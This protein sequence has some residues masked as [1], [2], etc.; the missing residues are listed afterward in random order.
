MGEF[1]TLSVAGYEI[2]SWKNCV[3]EE[4]A[5]LFTQDDEVEYD[6]VIEYEY[7]SLGNAK[8]LK[9]PEVVPGYRYINTAKNIIDRL[10]LIGCTLEASKERF[11]AGINE[12]LL[13]L[14]Q[15][16]EM[17]Q[18][19]HDAERAFYTAFTF[20]TWSQLMKRVVEERLEKIFTWERQDKEHPL[21][22]ENPILYRMLVSSDYHTFCFPCDYAAY[23]YRALLEVVK[24]SAYVEVDFT[25]LVGWVE[26]E[27]YSCCPPQQMLL[28][29]GSSD[30]RILQETLR[31]H[32]PHL[33]DYFSFMDFDA[34]SMPGGT[35]SLLNIVKAFIATGKGGRCIAL[36]DNDTAGH[37]ALRQLNNIKLPPYIKAMALPTLE[38]AKEYPTIGPQGVV[39]IDINGS[40]CSIELYLGRDV[41]TDKEGKLTPVH[42]GSFVQGM[43]RYQGELQ[44]KQAIQ[45]KYIRLLADMGRNPLLRQQHDWSGMVTL[46]EAIFSLC[47]C[48]G[49]LLE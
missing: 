42:W 18:D 44:N 26:E 43:R 29:E 7:D 30:K 45:E 14:E 16:N 38:L 1:A 21:K 11:Q 5:S 37:D 10:E 8:R 36:F 20:E 24:P 25:F 34:S 33:F 39:N 12:K 13:R 48:S 46:F 15:W 22:Q 35:G 19:W 23:M 17:P 49:Y 40:A 6:H 47:K 27:A 4:A 32:Y 9:K 28:T 3:G 2:D 41:L 31:A